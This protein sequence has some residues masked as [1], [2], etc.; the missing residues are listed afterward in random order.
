M[1]MLFGEHE[2]Q[3][4]SCHGCVQCVVQDHSS[5]PP[6][7]IPVDLRRG[8]KGEDADAVMYILRNQNISNNQSIFKALL[9]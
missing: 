8:E 5:L 6:I 7:G 2:S 1:G 3:S 9:G 4:H